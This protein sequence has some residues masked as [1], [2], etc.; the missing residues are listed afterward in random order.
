MRLTQ[1]QCALLKAIAA[2]QR[3]KDHRDIEGG[4]VY[5]LYALDETSQT[6]NAADVAVLIE[7]GLLNSNKKFPAATYWLTEQG[8]RFCHLQPA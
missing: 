2:G 1:R 4:K 7:A 3:L 6:V 8:Q 5:R